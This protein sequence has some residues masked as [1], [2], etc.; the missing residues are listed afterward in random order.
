MND[1]VNNFNGRDW[2]KKLDITG[3]IFLI[4]FIM[5]IFIINNLL[6]NKGERVRELKRYEKSI[7][8]IQSCY[9]PEIPGNNDALIEKLLI[10]TNQKNIYQDSVKPST[11]ILP[12]IKIYNGIDL[13]KKNSNTSKPTEIITN[14]DD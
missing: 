10:N 6:Y 5:L 2:K 7:D 14:K 4:I 1:S 3:I 11:L 9:V 8:S 12:E 13:E